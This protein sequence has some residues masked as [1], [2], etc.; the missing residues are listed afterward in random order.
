MT[1]EALHDALLASQR[2]GM[3]GPRPVDEVIDHAGAFVAALERTSGT[4]V[5]L[6]SGGG[7]PG[8]VIAV[9]RPD[10][11]LRLIDRRTARTDHLQ[12]LVRSLHLQARVIVI[13]GDATR[14]AVD[15]TADAV[16]ARGFGPP[17]STAAAAARWLGHDGLLVV[18]EPPDGPRRAWSDVEGFSVEPSDDRRVVRLR[19]VPRETTRSLDRPC[20]T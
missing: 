4:V 19:R 3:L 11:Q 5:D 10:L 6:G 17:A 1:L 9:A 14:V 8:L 20:S 2:L 13:G 7:V 12:R 15:Q 18:S 16:V